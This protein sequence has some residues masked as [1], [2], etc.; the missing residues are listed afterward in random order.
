MPAAAL[1]LLIGL[2]STL[3]APPQIP[4]PGPSQCD[5]ACRGDLAAR[6]DGRSGN[7]AIEV[8]VEIAGIAAGAGGS[9]AGRTEDD[10]APVPGDGSGE[11]SSC[12]WRP[13][14][15]IAEVAAAQAAVN[16]GQTPDVDPNMAGVEANVPEMITPVGGATT[17]F[18][19]NGTSA[20]VR[21]DEICNGA[22]TR[23][24]WISL[25][26][27]GSGNLVV[28]ITAADLVPGAYA[29]AVRALPTPI[30]RI[31]PADEDDR[32]QAIV[33]VPTF[34]W[35]DRRPGQWHTVSAT[36][37]AGGITVTVAAEPVRLVV[38]PGDGTTPVR[39]DTFMPVLREQVRYDGLP[40]QG[41]CSHTYRDSSAMAPNGETWPVAI[42]VVWHVTW[43]A[44]T[45]EAGELGYVSTTAPTRDLPVAE[46]QAVI[47]DT[48]D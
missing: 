33:Q 30:P 14:G 2:A 15:P 20:R 16:A 21:A 13:I 8:E 42:S 32:G 38:D 4:P 26:P 27:D 19:L 6:I 23:R 7:P 37:S 36:A 24:D 34:F 48:G 29:Q 28:Q 47:T 10:A 40:E 25:V 1:S 31:G 41:A 46:I 3:L 22:V 45:G 11:D 5:A 12:Y 9:T 18:E 44:N 43:T 39:C 35:L 17:W